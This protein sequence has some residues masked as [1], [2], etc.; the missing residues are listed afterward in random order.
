MKKHYYLVL[1]FVITGQSLFAQIVNIPD[2]SFKNLLINVNVVDSNG[3][4]YGDIDVDTN[5]DGEIQVSEA[6]SVIRLFLGSSAISSFVGIEA[7]I[8]I[9][10]ITINNSNIES[11]DL[12]Q[13][14]A[15]EE[16]YFSN[17]RDI[18]SLDLQANINLRILE[19]GNN[20]LQN[21]YVSGLANLEFLEVGRASS[22]SDQN[23]IDVLNLS[24]CT[25]LK[26]LQAHRSGIEAITFPSFS[27]IEL[28]NCKRNN[29]TTLDV[30][31]MTN[32]ID[33]DCDFNNL[34]SLNLSG[35]SNLTKL[36]CYNNDLTS[37]NFSG[38]TN[39]RELNCNSNELSS[40]NFSGLAN[41]SILYCDWNNF[42]T[43]D[44][45]SL[46][47]LTEL[48]C[49]SNDLTSLDVSG[50]TNLTYLSC[51]N[52]EITNLNVSNCPSF[53]T[54]V[55]SGNNLTSI[56]ATAMPN[57]KSLAASY[58][59]LAELDVSSYTNLISLGVNN[60]KITEL[61]I[62]S[63]PNITYLN[64]SWNPNLTSVFMKNG[65]QLFYTLFMENLQNLTYVC[66]D[67]GEINKVYVE[68]SDNLGQTYV[69]NNIVINSY[70][71]FTPGGIL[72]TIEGQTKLDIDMDGCD[73]ND[74]MF[75][76]LE[77]NITDGT[78]TGTFISNTS[79][80]YSIPVNAGIHTVTPQ[81][82]NP[83]YF[84]VTPTS[85]TIDFPTDASPNIQDFCVTPNGTYND[86]EVIIVPLELARPGFD[87]DYKI[88]YKNK[89]TTTLSGTVSLS[90]D[91][92]YMDLVSTNPTADTQSIGSLSWNYTNLA[93]FESRSIL[94]TMNLNTPTDINFPV[95]GNDELTYIATITPN[96]TDETPD[97]NTMTL[98]QTVVNSF[99]PN[100]KTCLEGATIPEDKVGEYVHYLIRFEN[101]GTASAINVVVKDDIDPNTYEI[102]TLKVLDGSHD[103]ITRIDGQKVEF[104]FENINLPFDDAN[105]DGYVL[106]KIKT[107][108]TLVLNDTFANEAEIFFDYNAPIITND[109]ITTVIAPLSVNETPLDVSIEAYPKPTS[110]ILYVKGAHAIKTI[111]LYTLQGRLVFSKALIG[112]QTET[113]ISVK[114]L[115]KGLYILKATSEKGVFI[116]KIIKQ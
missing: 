41:L 45:S 49:R 8:N 95:N 5:D 77:F 33:L 50:L 70:C 14:V 100:D 39:L 37:L 58:N 29:L 16:F 82:E 97:D 15:L 68:L 69:D 6:E 44:V 31:G 3:D 18:T 85:I 30:S 88:I 34:I 71:S 56:T 25:G 21:L 83:S 116:D 26:E 98:V 94:Y 84:T 73:A 54:L 112:N 113:N 35:A 13:N 12:S 59:D 10:K 91:D 96:A 48:S 27:T 43:L 19:C 52:N 78:N 51:A 103:Y 60:N 1:L 42:T 47:N 55:F 38:L 107:K 74:S 89:G 32:L 87:A 57:L 92:D 24:G 61:D 90:F 53:V 110:D 72:Y 108:T 22:T 9:E 81:F 109:E 2:A 67:E 102:S 46:N 86:L 115:S 101:T 23:D 99:D 62:S 4:G 75:P 20:S 80:N 66:V 17:N 65:F 36:S 106:F 11:L 79:G 28:I 7:F 93:P 114:T 64:C 104:I 40:L 76:N 111:E 63:N 105:N